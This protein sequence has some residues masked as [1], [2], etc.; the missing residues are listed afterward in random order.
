MAIKA[1][2]TQTPILQTKRKKFTQKVRRL[3]SSLVKGVSFV[4][5]N[6]G[7]IVWK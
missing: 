5:G 4:G 1:A 7:F 6:E 3:I 2:T